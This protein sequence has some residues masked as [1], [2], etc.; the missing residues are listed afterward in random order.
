MSDPDDLHSQVLAL[1][2]AQPVRSGDV[3]GVGG[4]LRRVCSATADA[5]SARGA[6]IGVLGHDG[7]RFTA[8]GSDPVSEKLEDVQFLLGEGPCTEAVARRRPVLVPDLDTA[9]ARRWPGYVPAMREHDI[10]AVFAFPLQVGAGCLGALDVFRSAPGS[11][12]PQQ[13]RRALLF[14]DTAMSI[15][16][17]AQDKAEDDTVGG[18]E[19]QIVHDATLFQAQGMVM[20][21]LGVSITEA[22]VRIR[23]HTF[24]ENLNVLDV[25]TDIVHGRLRLD[26]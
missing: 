18:F 10:R 9:A 14:A 16:L 22:M 4:H 24:A 13:L 5:L 19:D 20:A 7:Q 3:A 2:A 8:I 1:V 21:Q 23:A 25:A 11:L 6:G 26:R 17:D 15:L 12:T